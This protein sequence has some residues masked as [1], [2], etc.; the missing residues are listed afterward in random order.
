MKTHNRNIFLSEE[1]AERKEAYY[2]PY[3]RLA[4]VIFWGRSERDVCASANELT[5][6]LHEMV[7]EKEGWEI[8]GPADC[9]K[10]KVKDKYRRHVLVKAPTEEN[11]GSL[12]SQCA[13]K[14]T[15]RMGISMTIDVDAYDMM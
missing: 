6:A 3:S 14:L 10:A 13:V 12:I 1:V 8:L 9:V 4:N 7:G 11:I 5:E 15:K 2:P